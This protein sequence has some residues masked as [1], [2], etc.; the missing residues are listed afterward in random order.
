MVC[1]LNSFHECFETLKTRYFLSPS[2]YFNLFIQLLVYLEL[3]LALF[4]GKHHNMLLIWLINDYLMSIPAVSV[5][6]VLEHSW[7]F[8][9]F[10]PNITFGNYNCTRFSVIYC[11]TRPH[12]GNP[13]SIPYINVS[14]CFRTHFYYLF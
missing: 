10:P 6:L 12:F 7:V 1:L 5:P 14:Y 4:I 13:L 9:D 8:N 11:S 3:I 2:Y